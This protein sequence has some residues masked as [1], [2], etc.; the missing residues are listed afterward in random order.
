MIMPENDVLYQSKK[1]LYAQPITLG[2]YNKYKGWDMPEGE[3][4]SDKGY[5]VTYNKDS[6]DQHISW[7]PKDIFEHGNNPV[8]ENEYNDHLHQAM[9][10]N[11]EH[12]SIVGNELRVRIQAGP[13]NEV[14]TNGTDAESLLSFCRGL[15][16]SFNRKFPSPET[17]EVVSLLDR[18]V[19]ENQ[20]RTSKRIGAGIEGTSQPITRKI[21]FDSELRR[22]S[23]GLEFYSC[24]FEV[25]DYLRNSGV[26]VG[27]N[28]TPR[29]GGAILK[30][31]SAEMLRYIS[32]ENLEKNYT[33]I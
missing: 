2:E 4:P 1:T 33:R 11:N 25:A 26:L 14:G 20:R 18:A 22:G 9:P 15:Y 27:E 17:G 16:D 13:R 24:D 23:D 3:N 7:C 29:D 10:D 32:P 28:I 8:I 21:Q 31:K 5:L 30:D 6:A 12:M 19:I